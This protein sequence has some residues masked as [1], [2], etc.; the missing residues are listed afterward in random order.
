[1]DIV[2]GML[3][4][5]VIGMGVLVYFICRIGIEERQRL[6]KV[7]DKAEDIQTCLQQTDEHASLLRQAMQAMRDETKTM[8][9]LAEMQARDAQANNQAEVIAKLA[10]EVKQL[11]ESLQSVK[12]A[13]AAQALAKPQNP[14]AR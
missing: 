11:T 3:M 13:M 8:P 4:V 2:I 9:T 1:M 12:S 6:A 7:I 14:F 10:K 5:L